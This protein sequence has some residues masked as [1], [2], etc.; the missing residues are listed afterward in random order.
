VHLIAFPQTLSENQVS[1][2]LVFIN[3][4]CFNFSLLLFLVVIISNFIII[5]CFYY[6]LSFTNFLFLLFVVV[7]M[8]VIKQQACQEKKLQIKQ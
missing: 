8:P 1:L 3:F 2:S 6:N 7:I 5:Y 4:C